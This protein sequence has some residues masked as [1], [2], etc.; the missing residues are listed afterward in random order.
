MSD[1]EDESDKINDQPEWMVSSD[2][3][4]GTKTKKS[5][6]V[7]KSTHLNQFC[8]KLPYCIPLTHHLKFDKHHLNN[9]LKQ[10]QI[11]HCPLCRTMRCV[12]VW[13]T[14]YSLAFLRE[15]SKYN[16]KK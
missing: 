2:K 7:H 16:P 15:D 9:R 1:N 3:V 6:S 12:C 11:S 14:K 4:V 5:L 8:N 13:M 10:I